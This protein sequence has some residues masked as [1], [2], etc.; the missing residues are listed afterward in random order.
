MVTSGSAEKL[1]SISEP[2]YTREITGND[3]ATV[4]KIYADFIVSYMDSAEDVKLANNNDYTSGLVVEF[5]QYVNASSE[6]KTFN[7]TTATVSNF[8]AG[9]DANTTYQ[10]AGQSG[11]NAL[12]RFS[13]DNSGYN[14]YNRLDYFLGFNN[15]TS[16]INRVMKA[17]YYVSDGTTVTLSEPVYFC[18]YDTSVAVYE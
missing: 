5:N 17:Y 3:S 4:D 9:N 14:N 1:A 2:V 11:L 15:G 12:V 13:I 10:V 16:W 6:T 18:L 8:A 7:S